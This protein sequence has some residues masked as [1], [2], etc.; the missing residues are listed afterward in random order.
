M[1]MMVYG[2]AT[3]NLTNIVGFKKSQPLNAWNYL[4]ESFENFLKLSTCDNHHK[5]I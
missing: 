2:L 1:K 3:N 5:M 4:W